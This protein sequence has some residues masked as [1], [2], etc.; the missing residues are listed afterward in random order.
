MTTT[1][2]V[3]P[4]RRGA[5]SRQVVLDAAERV[6]ARDGYEAATVA[7]IVAEAGIPPSSIYHYFGSKEG[8]LLA[9]LER[10]AQR[11]LDALPEGEPPPGPRVQRVR[12][13]VTVIGSTL[14]RRPD[15]LRLLIALATQPPAAGNGEVRAVINRVRAVAIER[16]AAQL[17]AIFAVG[18]DAPVTRDLARFAMAAFDG[19]FVAYQASPDMRLGQTLAYLPEALVA[20]ARRARVG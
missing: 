3:T 7:R 15:F 1:P 14:E 18:A 16:L 2:D 19:A 6:M 8:I 20:I 9:V 17:A 11:F 4:N 13:L 5:R 10:G 12:V